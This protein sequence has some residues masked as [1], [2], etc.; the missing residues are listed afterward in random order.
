MTPLEILTNIGKLLG[1]M[2][3]AYFVIITALALWIFWINDEKKNYPSMPNKYKRLFK[4]GKA[5]HWLLLGVAGLMIA[6]A[7]TRVLWKMVTTGW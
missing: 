2:G 3:I 5:E 6:I 4:V 1:F 7:L